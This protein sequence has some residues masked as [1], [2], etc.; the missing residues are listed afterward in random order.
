MTA[1]IDLA[2]P[3]TGA[4]R[5]G[6]DPGRRRFAR[7]GPLE[8]ES[9][10]QLD[11]TLAYETWGQ[12]DAE[13]SN[14]V[15]VLHAL[16]GDS[17]VR[18][19]AGPA[20]PSPGWWE[21]LIGPG[22]AIDTDRC[23][24][25]APNV[26]GG[27]Q[28]STG[29]A[30]TA[31]DGAPYGSRFPRLTCRD[32]V[33]AERA[34]ARQLG[35]ASWAL[36]IGGSMG[37]MRALEWGIERPEEVR[38][39][40]VI[41]SCARAGAD[42]LAWNAA[43][44]AAIRAS[45]GFCGGDYYD[46]APGEGPHDGLGVARRIAHTTYRTAAELEDRFGNRRSPAAKGYEVASYLDHHAAKLSRRFDANAYLTLVGAMDSHDVGRGRGG[47]G[48]ALGRVSARTL[49]AGVDSDRLFPMS[50]SEQIAAH[51]PGAQL[52]QISSSRGHDAFLVPS[53][54]LTGWITALLDD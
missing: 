10:A 40:A 11:A 53:P 41:A 2:E 19:P 15:L 39:L 54:A 20:H 31:A 5:E 29:P 38:R 42:Q 17:H 47:L 25:V 44:C 4:W 18:G 49:V 36:V 24:V 51:V 52:E 26:L 12:L 33:R 8:L 7:L 32:Q 45:S 1:L 46:R 13:R 23:F 34:L 14:A 22:R 9:G 43:Q 35:I 27:C 3:V 28:G 21:D 48:A 50:M 6:D 37:G 30:S 16:T